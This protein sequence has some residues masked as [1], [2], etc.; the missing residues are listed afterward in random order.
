MSNLGSDAAARSPNRKAVLVERLPEDVLTG[1]QLEASSTFLLGFEVAA[2]RIPVQ[3]ISRANGPPC[4]SERP[5]PTRLEW[6]R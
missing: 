5:L 1:R 4:N 3:A 2:E 6:A